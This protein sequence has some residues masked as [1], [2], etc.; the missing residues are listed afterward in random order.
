MRIHETGT[1]PEAVWMKVADALKG[2]MGE[3]P[4]NSY[5]APSTLRR[6]SSGSLYLVTQTAYS[7]DWLRR[8]V[9]GACRTCGT[10]TTR[11]AAA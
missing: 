10:S 5:V 8:N 7:R 1:P 4:F 11:C 3:G 6:G 2:E 9:S